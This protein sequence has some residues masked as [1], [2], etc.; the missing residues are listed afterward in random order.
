MIWLLISQGF[1]H[2]VNSN[3]ENL[4]HY[5]VDFHGK[6]TLLVATNEIT[7]D[8]P[9]SP[10]EKIFPEFTSQ[11]AEH[12]GSEIINLLSSDFSTTTPVEKVASEIT[13]MET[14]KTYFEYVVMRIVCG[15]PEIT[16]QGTTE[17]WQKILD[18]T[19]QLGKYDLTWWTSEL[20]PILEEFVKASKG[21]IDRK[22]W[23]GMFK[24]HSKD[25]P[26]G[27]PIITIDGWIVKF[28]PYNASGKRNDLKTLSSS[29]YLPEEIVKVDLLYYDEETEVT[30]PLELWAGFF[31]LEQNIKNY[32]LTPK[33]GWMIR[34]KD[35][36][37]IGLQQKYEY[38]LKTRGAIEI[39]VKEIPEAI[40]KLTEIKKLAIQFIGDVIIPDRLADIKIQKLSIEGKIDKSEEARIRQLFPDTEVTILNYAVSATTT[41]A[42]NQQGKQATNAALVIVDGKEGVDINSLSPENI[43]TFKILKD[44]EAIEKY[45]EKGKNG[46]V[47]ITT[48]K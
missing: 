35:V 40:F 20:E 13:I 48:K 4:R 37:Q 44:Q 1:A 21:K 18:K 6:I 47:I 27:G 22:F 31:G 11:I 34:K 32:A 23:K 9:Q 29:A 46:V 24:Y 14:M 8:D 15:I 25:I 38:D 42:F 43:E 12:T 5:F 39:R 17:D 16:L 30:T 3:P 2:H 45:G 7:L 41:S 19:K 36:E 10:W 26:C 33:I 28:F